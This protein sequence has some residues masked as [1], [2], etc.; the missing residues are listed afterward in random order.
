MT[1]ALSLP[2]QPLFYQPHLANRCVKERTGSKPLQECFVLRSE[3]GR[4]RTYY[5]GQI[6]QVLL[7]LVVLRREGH[8]SLP[9][10]PAQARKRVPVWVPTGG[11]AVVTCN[12]ARGKGRTR[13]PDQG[14]QLQLRWSVLGTRC[15]VARKIYSEI[16]RT[17]SMH[18]VEGAQII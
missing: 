4:W 9:P 17:W 7:P 2:W 12:R 18:H 14:V 8:V 15:M 11:A 16:T 10:A 3:L 1:E 13:F 5:A 6:S